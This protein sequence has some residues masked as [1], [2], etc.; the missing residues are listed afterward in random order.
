MGNCKNEILTEFAHFQH[1]SCGKIN[2]LF[3]SQQYLSDFFVG[4]Q[5]TERGSGLFELIACLR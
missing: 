1:F 5:K 3:C 4:S 2:I